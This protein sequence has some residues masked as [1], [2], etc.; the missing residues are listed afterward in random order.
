MRYCI[1]ID[2]GGSKTDA[3][4]FDETGHI[5]RR[6]VGKGGNAT[7]IGTE[8]AR[9]RMDSCLA[10]IFP[11]APGPVSALYG[12]VAG[13][14]PNG[15][16]Y[17]ESA[18]RRYPVGRIC[19][20]DDGCNL[21]SGTLG[22][23]D[24][25]G[26]VCGTGSSLFVRVSGQP[27][28]HIGGKGYLID[29]GGSGFALGQEALCMALRAVDGRCRPT[30]LTE[31]LAQKIGQPVSDAVVP[32][33]HQGGRPYIASLAGVVFAGR[34]AGDWAC[35]EIFERGAALMA[36]LTCAAAASFPDRFTVVAGG[37]IAAHF[38]EYVQA[39]REKASPRADLILQTAPP[40]YG[41]AVEAMWL[42]EIP[43]DRSFR[44]QFLLD[45]LDW[46]DIHRDLF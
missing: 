31:L 7:D 40:V 27:L 21:I 23:S 29:T 11:Y 33:V 20:E 25:C 46:A 42:A 15:D 9:T 3:V 5:L 19:F 6:H 24:G 35:E 36:D 43:L 2:G 41:A 8:D 32:L 13:V 1:A 28:R 12:G 14:L 26:M 22:H 4:L 34:K 38:P 39:I 44:E 10:Q 16:I 18:A 17:S 37:G 45:Y 30:I